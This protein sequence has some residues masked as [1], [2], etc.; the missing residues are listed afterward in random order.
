ML[1]TIRL[2][3]RGEPTDVDVRRSAITSVA[4]LDYPGVQA[5]ADAGTLHPSIRL[6]PEIGTLRLERARE[7]HAISLDIPDAEIVTGPTGTGR[8]NSGP[9]C[10]WRSTT[11]RSAC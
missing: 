7:R 2:D 10:R 8:W 5:D 4:Q 3:N 1:W 11:R 6:L 9:S